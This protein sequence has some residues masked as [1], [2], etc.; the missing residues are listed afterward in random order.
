MIEHEAKILDVDHADMERRILDKGG[1]KIAERFMR[2]RVYDII[3][4]DWSKWI[5]LRDD[6]TTTTLC[7]KEIIHE[8]IDGTHEHEI[9]VNDFDETDALLNTL[10]HVSRNYQENQRTSYTLDGAAIELDLW[11][12]IPTFME[13]EAS[14]VDEVVR[15]ASTLGVEQ[16]DLKGGAYSVYGHYGIDLFAIPNL[17]F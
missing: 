1:V 4:G 14:S 17:R 13:I 9:T 10:G 8:G 3:P 12:L 11:P 7:T 15:I 2:R 5:R 6:G 16:A